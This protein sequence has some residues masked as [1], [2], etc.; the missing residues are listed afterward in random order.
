[1]R[2]F[3]SVF[4]TRESAVLI[5]FRRQLP[6]GT[7][8]HG[9][10]RRH[11]LAGIVGPGVPQAV[12]PIMTRRI[13]ARDKRVNARDQEVLLTGVRMIKKSRAGSLLPRSNFHLF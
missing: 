12:I 1:M 9:A 6:E 5:L 7:P 10:A 3:C 13:K 8:G 4:L 11:G 2:I